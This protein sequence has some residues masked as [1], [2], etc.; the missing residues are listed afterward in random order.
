[1]T[2]RKKKSDTLDIRLP[3]EQKQAFMSAVSSNQ[4]TASEAIRRFIEDYVSKAEATEHPNPVQELTMT[5]NRHRFKTL[6]TAA[7]AA[8]GI[9]IMAMMPTA[10]ASPF[11]RLDKNKDG[12]LTEGEI[13]EGYDAD[14]IA[15]LD[16]DGSGGISPE[17]LEAAGNK[18]VIRSSDES[19][20]ENGETIK[21]RSIKV[22]NFTDSTVQIDDNV[23]SS[24][25]ITRTGDSELTEEELEA[26]IGDAM[27]IVETGEGS[28]LRVTIDGEDINIDEAEDTN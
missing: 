16:T 13:I 24:V 15:K 7:A 1:M 5:L 14:I 11:E 20:G 22:L 4:E 18:I 3:H 9:S 10:A 2:D 19:V 23:Q 25:V 8:C 6:G 21:K 26:L 12:M 27:T 17:E 28:R